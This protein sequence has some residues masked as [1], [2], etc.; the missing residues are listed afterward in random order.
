MLLQNNMKKNLFGF[1]GGEWLEKDFAEA[2]QGLIDKGLAEKI[3]LE[4]K[5]LF[6]ITTLGSIVGKHLVSDM[7]SKN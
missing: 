4:N 1:P 7:S 5:E 2:M 3:L 6:Q